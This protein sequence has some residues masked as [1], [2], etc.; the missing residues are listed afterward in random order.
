MVRNFEC[1]YSPSSKLWLSSP[2]T[3]DTGHR[4]NVV[5][6]TEHPASHPWLQLELEVG[7][8]AGDVVTAS[9]EEVSSWELVGVVVNHV[10]RLG[11][12][13]GHVVDATATV[14][15]GSSIPWLW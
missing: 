15:L 9:A 7:S 2:E 10:A 11:V 1:A 4:C 5:V 14:S 8:V 3:I 6:V 13:P 12:L